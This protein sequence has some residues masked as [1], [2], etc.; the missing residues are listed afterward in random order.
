MKKYL[1][2]LLF[3]AVLVIAGC[4]E[5]DPC[6]DVVCGQGICVEGTCE[7]PEGY[8][9]AS[10]ETLEKVKYFGAYTI[11]ESDCGSEFGP[12]TFTRIT[13]EEKTDGEVFDVILMA[14]DISETYTFEGTLMNDKL[15]VTANADIFV[16]N[17]TGDFSDSANF[18]GIYQVQG[19]VSCDFTMSK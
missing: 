18:V 10:C 17:I 1:N 13:I 4:G 6:E 9:G 5:D 14:E 8:E 15:D 16:L 12:I 19:V 2:Q 7:C 11:T 3:I